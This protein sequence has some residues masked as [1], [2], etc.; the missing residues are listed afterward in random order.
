M[1]EARKKSATEAHQ[2]REF[3]DLLRRSAEPGILVA[4]AEGRIRSS[5]T[6]A[7][8]LLHLRLGE[9]EFE[10]LDSLPAPLPLLIRSALKDGTVAHPQVVAVRVGA[11]DRSVWVN[12]FRLD[13]EPGRLPMLVVTLHDLSAARDLESKT[14]RLQRL[15]TVG[16][17]SAG[18][19]HEIK[20]A[21]VAIKTYVDLLLEKEPDVESALLVRREVGRIDSLTSQLLSFAGPARPV[22][23]RVRVHDLLK[24]AVRLVRHPLQ[25]RG[26]E[27]VLLLEAAGDEVN[28]DA[29][30]LEQAFLN[31]L[32]N[33]VEAMAEGG[34]LVVR[35]ELVVATEMVSKFEPGRRDTQLQVEVKDSGPGIPEG[36]VDRLFT[37]F[38]TTK[39]G[40]TGLGLA[41]TQRIVRE[42]HGRISVETK[43]GVGTTFRV[44]LPLIR[45]A[46]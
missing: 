34:R 10:G 1:P 2:D 30:Q 9:P 12:C 45:E 44:L 11:E 43:P 3:Y 25:Q 17:L 33:A 16:T 21:L 46:S 27:E 29:K 26:V 31:L 39:P 24:D 32:L 42:H 13:A 20:N 19:T 36:I 23:S 15:A 38:L 28:A 6:L 22:F 4:D 18:V 8:R 5:N 40:G 14:S 41:I 35:T 7:A 37:P